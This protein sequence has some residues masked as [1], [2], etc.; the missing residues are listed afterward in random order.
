MSTS[1]LVN[2]CSSLTEGIPD[3]VVEFTGLN[4]VFSNHFSEVL[5]VFGDCFFNLSRVLFVTSSCDGMRRMYRFKHITRDTK[6][7][8]VVGDP[9]GHSLSP[10]IHNAALQKLGIDAAYLPLRVP[11]DAFADTIREFEFLDMQG[12]SVTIPH[13]QTAMAFAER[14]DEITRDSGAANTLLK[15]SGIWTATN[16]DLDAAMES[17]QLLID[18]SPMSGDTVESKQVLILGAGGVARAI[19]LGVV[20]AGGL[21]IIANRNHEKAVALADELGCQQV[22]WENRGAQYHDIIV[23][24]T[25]VGMYPNMN[26]T[27]YNAPWMRDHALV[28]DTIYNPENTLLIKQ[29]RDRGCPTMSGLEMFVRQ[30]ARQFEMF[31][32]QE[33]PLE[34]MREAVRFGISA[35]RS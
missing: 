25:P 16:T 28:F 2:L 6:L 30:A 3:I 13:K 34:L 4:T 17:L 33:P 8:G 11:G 21:A 23:N 35:T 1:F 32:D 5:T 19:G 29:A 12:Y 10:L 14:V 31:T 27:P 20:R 26:E 24:C 15:R 7:F 9:I 22:T 18:S